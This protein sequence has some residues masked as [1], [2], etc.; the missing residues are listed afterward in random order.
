MPSASLKARAFH[1]MTKP[2]GPMCNLACTYCYYLDKK[3]LF[4]KGEQFRMSD[5]VLEAYI[6]QHIGGQDVPTVEFAWQGGEPTLLGVDFFEKVVDLQ[7][8][9]ANGKKITNAIQTNGTL[10]SDEWCEFF[11]ENRFLVGISIDGPARLHDRHRVDRHQRPT[12]HSVMRGLDLLRKHGTEFNTLTVVGRKNSREPITVYRF[13]KEVGSR[14]MQF[15]PLVEREA[16]AAANALGVDLALP[17]DPRGTAHPNPPVTSWSVG[18]ERY[19]TFLVGIFDEWVR[20]DVGSFFVQAFDVALGSW[21]GEPPGLCTFAPV[22]GGAMALEH[23]G[24][25]YSCDH[26]VYPEYN[27]G[28]ILD[29]TVAEMANSARQVEFGTDKSKTLPGYCRECD[30]RFACNGECPKHRFIETPDGE[31]G[32]NYLCPS[33]KKFFHHVD[34]YMRQMAEF[35]RRGQPASLIMDVP[36]GAT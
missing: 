3:G 27:L 2:N 13:L 35:L 23:D 1:V 24:S 17:P 22:C 12:F 15:I 19:G 5:D 18:S 14:F 8:T 26:Y 4:A 29:V 6:R 25:L 21:L 16:D 28:N 33:Y 9:Y 20:S 10:L 31:P 36:S 34:P 11:S 32:L 7:A 30:V